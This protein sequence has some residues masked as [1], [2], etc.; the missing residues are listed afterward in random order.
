MDGWQHIVPTLALTMLRPLGMLVLMPMFSA[1]ALGGGLIRNA[2]VLVMALPAL[3][4]QLAQAAQFA[5]LSLPALALLVMQEFV[6][7]LAMGFCAT[8]PF[9]AIDMASTVIDTV[10][11]T[12]MASVLNPM[13]EEQSSVFGVL[14]TQVLAVLFL[15]GGGFNAMLTA[16][17]ASYQ[18]MPLLG[19]WHLSASF[20][21]FI[22]HQWQLMM[23]LCIGF[24]LPALVVMVLIDAALGLVNRSAQQLNVFF[25]AMPIKSALA[26]FV[27]AIGMSYALGAFQQRFDAFGGVV[28]NLLGTMR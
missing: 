26:L 13:L 21:G 12:S 20:P 7:G 8:I 9:W 23:E 25:V 10:R 24:A 27:L 19:G 2:L 5:E 28:A 14:F 17:Y 4:M 6:I 22:A 18:S 3:P 11:G 15:V 1:R 16:L